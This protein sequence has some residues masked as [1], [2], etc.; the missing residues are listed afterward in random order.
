MSELLDDPVQRT[1]RLRM[2]DEQL[3]SRDIR[4]PLVIAAMTKVPRHLFVPDNSLPEAYSDGPLLIGHGQTISQPYIVAS[5]TQALA[6]SPESRVLE[7]GTGSGYQTAVL[8]E[9]FREVYTIEIIPELCRDSERRLA[10]LGYSNVQIRLGDGGFGWPEAA[11]FDGILVTAA[12]PCVP[13]SLSAQ[14]AVGGRMVIPFIICTGHQELRV[15]T[16]SHSGLDEQA[17]YDVRFVL[18]KGIV[19]QDGRPPVT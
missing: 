16:R 8:A 2:V 17:M 18:M 1:R 13:V 4:D 7:I 19:D 10:V 15:I 9:I 14:L 6:L 5:M 3:T 11:P 12:A